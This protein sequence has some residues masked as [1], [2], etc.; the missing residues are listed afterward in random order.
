MWHVGM[1]VYHCCKRQH[2]YLYVCRW[3]ARDGWA[4]REG[5][6]ARKALALLACMWWMQMEVVAIHDLKNG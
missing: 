3:G 1:L 5:V 6:R 4:R 2:L